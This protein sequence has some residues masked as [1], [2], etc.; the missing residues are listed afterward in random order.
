MAEDVTYPLID[1]LLC[2]F[3]LGCHAGVK[4]GFEAQT[5]FAGV[6]FLGLAP[7]PFARFKIVIDSLLERLTQLTD[8]F[9]METDHVTDA[10]NMADQQLVFVTVFNTSGIAA[11]GLD[12]LPALKDGDSYS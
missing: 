5:Q 2:Q 1:A 4:S 10:G 12:I 8:R 6:R 11:V 7:E 9:A 3:G